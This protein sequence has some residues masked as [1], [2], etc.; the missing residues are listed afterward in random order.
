MRPL[1]ALRTRVGPGIAY[2]ASA[3]PQRGDI[4]RFV[5]VTSGRAGS[6]LLGQLLN[7]HPKVTCESEILDS[8]RLSSDRFLEGRARRSQ[9]RGMVAYGMKVKP[10]HIHEIQQIENSG[11]WLRR[12]QARG[13]KVIYVGRSDRI[14]QGVSVLRGE[15]RQWH[16][17]ASEGAPPPDPMEL[18]PMQ[19]IATMY[20]IQRWENQIT[21][22]LE[23]V[24]FLDVNY[25]RDLEDA[26][27]QAAT[28]ERA[29]DFLHI[30]PSPVPVSSGIVRSSSKRIQDDVTNWDEIAAEIRRNRFAQYLKDE[31][32]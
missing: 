8:P 20:I 16:Y 6:E 22:L 32:L 26:A 3:T 2:V 23:G 12:L 30:E 10:A 29:W 13:W 14:R 18:D 21:Q 11:D 31:Q 1:D 24:D 15:L 4:T 25:E 9:Q 27:K 17:V 28:V 7:S 5:I 19:L